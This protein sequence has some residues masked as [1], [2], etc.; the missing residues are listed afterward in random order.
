MQF[1]WPV[2]F[3]RK[4]S[5]ESN[6]LRADAEAAELRS[7]TAGFISTIN[8][9]AQAWLKE[10]LEAIG[11]TK[12]I[13]PTKSLQLSAVYG[14]VRNISEDIAGLPIHIIQEDTA[15]K[16]RTKLYKHP[17]YLLMNVRA[18]DAL[19]SLEFRKMMHAIKLLRG[20]SYAIIIRNAD[21][22]PL[23]LVPVWPD[24]VIINL[25]S[26]Y[27]LVYRVINM[28]ALNGD[29]DPMDMLH[30]KQL[31][32][33]GVRGVTPITYAA[34]SMGVTLSAQE[35]GDSFFKNGA[36]GGF[37]LEFPGKVGDTAI[38]TLKDTWKES[39]TG[40][41]NAHSL[42]VIPEGGKVSKI[43]IAN[44]EAQFVESREF[45][46]E[47]ICRWYRIPPHKLQHLGRATHSN[48]EHQNIEYVTDT[49][50]PHIR[51]EEEQVRAKLLTTAEMANTWAETNAAA[52]LRGDIKTRSEAYQKFIT[53]G[54][55]EPN[56]ARALENWSARDGGD[57][58]FMP[59]NHIPIDM[60]DQYF[61]P[62]T[63][64]REGESHE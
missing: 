61:K 64:K 27:R 19:L 29:Y 14:A 33:D 1:Q 11:S 15:G 57:R 49:L 30:Y 4:Q 17:A 6:K 43:S 44:N 38:K 8:S 3:S 18:N 52:L 28:G 51:Q 56:E 58:L 7:A 13:S 24:N 36:T 23:R 41:E 45:G 42:K 16:K 59:L 26:D 12:K 10:A 5:S 2:V 46:V 60:I 20:N 34:A 40:T 47:E 35:Y 62:K 39:S 37:T 50:M 53:S 32:F 25:T 9:T 31:T 48:I 55:M 21:A 63:E 54:V 22:T